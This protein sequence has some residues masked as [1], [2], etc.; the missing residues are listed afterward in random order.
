VCCRRQNPDH[1]GTRIAVLERIFARRVQLVMVVRVL[2]RAH[3]E[4]KFL[5]M[6]DQINDQGCLPLILATDNVQAVHGESMPGV[7]GWA[8]KI[9]DCNKIIFPKI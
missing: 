1:V 9:G 3:P 8:G 2:D 6:A 7:Y 5:Q 4:A